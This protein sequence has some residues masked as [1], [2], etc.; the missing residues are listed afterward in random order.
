[1]TELP[2]PDRMSPLAD[3]LRRFVEID[4]PNALVEEIVMT[5]EA[6]AEGELLTAAE[7]RDTI[8]YEAAAMELVRQIVLPSNA[9]RYVRQEAPVIVANPVVDVALGIASET[10]DE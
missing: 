9:E 4:S 3:R 8:D 7:W 10:P 6:R 2:S 5:I 1:M